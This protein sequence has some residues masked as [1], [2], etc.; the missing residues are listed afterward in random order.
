MCLEE[1]R[2]RGREGIRRL[3]HD[4]RRSCGLG[5]QEGS[6]LRLDLWERVCRGASGP[7]GMEGVEWCR[8]E[9]AG[10]QAVIEPV[11]L[12]RIDL[13]KVRTFQVVD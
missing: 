11:R 9:L 3:L 5:L 8:L 1:I 12:K 2:G 13:E 4:S 10:C 7:R 6:W